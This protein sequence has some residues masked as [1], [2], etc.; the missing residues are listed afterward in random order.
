G[1]L[2]VPTVMVGLRADQNTVAC[3][4]SSSLSQAMSTVGFTGY[5]DAC[6]YDESSMHVCPFIPGS[7]FTGLMGGINQNGNTYLCY[8]PAHYLPAIL[9]GPACNP[10][11]AQSSSLEGFDDGPENAVDGNTDGWFWNGSVTHTNNAGDV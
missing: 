8:N 4:M 5:F 3:Q 11:V 6:T 7:S 2:T 1:S 10:S 9:S